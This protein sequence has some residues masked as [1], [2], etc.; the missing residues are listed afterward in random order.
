[1]AIEGRTQLELGIE[2]GKELS[3]EEADLMQELQTALENDADGIQDQEAFKTLVT[4][5][6]MNSKS[7]LDSM[8]DKINVTAT[9]EETTL[10]A[11]GRMVN[12]Q[13]FTIPE[14]APVTNTTETTLTMAEHIDSGEYF[15][16]TE[17][18]KIDALQ[19]MITDGALE[20]WVFSSLQEGVG[21][22]GY[23]YTVLDGNMY[24]KVDGANRFNNKLQMYDA[25]TDSRSAVSNRDFNQ[26]KDNVDQQN[27]NAQ[28]IENA[29]AQRTSKDIQ[30]Y[31]DAANN[32]PDRFQGW[33]NG[34]NDAYGSD[35]T[36][37]T[38]LT[39]LEEQ[40]TIVEAQE[41]AD[42]AKLAA[43]ELLKV[44]NAIDNIW[45]GFANATV[46][47]LQTI[48]MALSTGTMIVEEP[49]YDATGQVTA[50][51]PTEV[52][53]TWDNILTMP[54][55]PELGSDINILVDGATAIDGQ[56]NISA[57]D[58]QAKI[59]DVAY[60][61]IVENFVNT[62]MDDDT[63]ASIEQGELTL[64]DALAASGELPDGATVDAGVLKWYF[65]TAQ[66]ERVDELTDA[67][68]NLD[69]SLNYY[70]NIDNNLI[71]DE[72]LTWLGGYDHPQTGRVNNIISLLSTTDDAMTKTRSLQ[73]LI[74]AEPD[75]DF[76]PISYWVL[77][78]YVAD[79]NHAN[80][81]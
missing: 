41:T 6:R 56:V 54:G 62:I 30:N 64:E 23:V 52:D 15:N 3:Q 61:R 21:L 17:R 63:W 12:Q 24:A 31:I 29:L 18:A 66:T 79:P 4:E 68:D 60:P 20:E 16:E 34:L 8:S 14:M 45:N 58:L 1:M 81:V 55:F 47:E 67:I 11:T 25:D 22:D 42:A 35:F 7:T 40:F 70:S 28:V 43:E 78:N 57:E 19:A 49:E 77:M 48:V 9:D 39:A 53:A 74:G 2:D 10:Q 44:Q 27:T 72:L 46:D 26:I 32:D 33:V 5:Y 38:F 71:K 76:G 51:V 75:G 73:T 50:L 65:D 36:A 59:E 69:I 13:D 80:Q 37:E